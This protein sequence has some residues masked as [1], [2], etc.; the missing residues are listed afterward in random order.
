MPSASPDSAWRFSSV[1]L[2]YRHTDEDLAHT[3]QVVLSGSCTA[4]G[5]VGR[6][7]LNS[8]RDD[9]GAEIS[10]RVKVSGRRNNNVGR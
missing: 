9:A 2:Q 4:R 10:E 1:F 5:K 7:D 3:S 6:R 8:R